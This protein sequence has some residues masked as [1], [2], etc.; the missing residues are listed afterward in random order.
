M[1]VVNL[2]I[3]GPA[4]FPPRQ[5]ALFES[6]A[7]DLIVNDANGVENIFL[8]DVIHGTTTLVSESTNGTPGNGES[9]EATMTPNGRY[10]AFVSAASNLV[11]GDTNGIPDVFVRDMQAGT[12]VLASPGATAVPTAETPYTLGSSSEEPIISVDGRYVAF[13]STATNLVSGHTLGEVYMRDLSQGITIW[14]SSNAQKPGS[15][16]QLRDAE[17]SNG[18]LVTV[19]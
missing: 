5:Y 14:V 15:P 11:V 3:H 10:V 2:R 1:N 9:R 17:P 12:T 7:P 13:F 4:P 8:R 19:Y 18:R 16:R 6:T